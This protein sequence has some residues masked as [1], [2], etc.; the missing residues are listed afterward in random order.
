MD[1]W[2]IERLARSHERGGFSC[3][4]PAL[5]NFIV[6]LVSQYEKR[7]LGRTYVAVRSGEK[8]VLG[9]YTLASS[10]VAFQN[11][12]TIVSTKLPRHPVPVA[13]L[14]RLAVDRSIQG[15]GLGRRLLMDALRRCVGLS[16]ELGIF[17]VEVQ[18]ID[19]AAREFYERFGFVC[20]EDND[21]HLYLPISTAEEAFGN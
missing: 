10:S 7:K 2:L 11:M 20:L 17:A 5:D 6:S 4:H 21:L 19:P 9:Y 15:Q 14:A 3:R 8:R 1:E 16:R 12:P 18:A 13:L